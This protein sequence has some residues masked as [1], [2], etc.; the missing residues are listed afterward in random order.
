MPCELSEVSHWVSILRQNPT[1]CT[2]FGF[3]NRNTLLPNASP[4]GILVFVSSVWNILSF[5]LLV[6]SQ[7]LFILQIPD[8]IV[9]FYLAKGCIRGKCKGIVRGEGGGSGYLKDACLSQHPYNF[10]TMWTERIPANFIARGCLLALL[11]GLFF[12]QESEHLTTSFCPLNC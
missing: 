12:C 9:S 5:S 6:S 8:K 7:C 10:S 2:D 1:L 4:R 11:C 3:G